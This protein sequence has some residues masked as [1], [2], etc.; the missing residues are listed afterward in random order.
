VRSGGRNFND[1]IKGS[2]KTR[3]K[4]PDNLKYPLKLA[5]T[6]QDVIKFKMVKFLQENLKLQVQIWVEL[7]RERLDRQ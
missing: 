3:N 5:E 7:H 2:A 1:D 6:K 4:F